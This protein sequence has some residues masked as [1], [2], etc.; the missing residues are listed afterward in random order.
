VVRGQRLQRITEPGSDKLRELLASRQPF[1]FAGPLESWPA[2]KR[3]SSL[4]YLD[5]Q[6]GHRL[7][8][9]EMGGDVG[10]ESW[11][12]E[13]MPFSRFLQEAWLGNPV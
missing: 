6:V 13:L 3:W 1:V 5:S 9:T 12:E 10:G 2:R 11:K 7:V 4:A 8:P